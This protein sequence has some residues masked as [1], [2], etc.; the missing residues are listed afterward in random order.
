MN[1]DLYFPKIFGELR[2]RRS[3]HDERRRRLASDGFRPVVYVAPFVTTRCLEQIGMISAIP[4]Y[5]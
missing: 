3:E 5:Q 1:L 2:R 4:H